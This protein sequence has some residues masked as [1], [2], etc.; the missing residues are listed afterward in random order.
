MD[1]GEL[2]TSRL[3]LRRFRPSDGPGLYAYLSRPEAV[4]YEPYPVQTAPECERLAAERADSADFWAVC[5]PDGVLVGNLYLHRCE[6]EG[7][8]TWELGYVFHPDHWGHGYASE[9]A[10]ALVTACFTSW[11]AHRLTARCD[12]RN[13]RS[14]RLLDRIGF[15]RE[16]L[17]LQNASFDTDEDG[18]PI[19]KDTILYGVLS[20]EWVPIAELSESH[21]AL[22]T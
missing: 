11:D 3:R 19:W 13:P 14:W 21:G 22:T 2:T 15:R 6:P 10:S 9:A 8:R 12:S 17:L 1:A 16:G 4:Q 20:H 18:T 5:L 7:W